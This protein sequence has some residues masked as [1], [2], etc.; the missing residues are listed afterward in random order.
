MCTKTHNWICKNWIISW[1]ANWNTKR[2]LLCL[3]S[4]RPF[5]MHDYSFMSHTE[6]RT[7][8]GQNHIQQIR[9]PFQ[10]HGDWEGANRAAEEGQRVLEFIYRPCPRRHAWWNILTEEPQKLYSLADYSNV[11]LNPPVRIFVCE[12]YMGAWRG[13]LHFSCDEWW[14]C[15]VNFVTVM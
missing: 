3:F 7:S 1:P 10:R 9:Q 13:V 8:S 2:N 11:H 15:T 4:F 5:H 12:R 6:R 14:H